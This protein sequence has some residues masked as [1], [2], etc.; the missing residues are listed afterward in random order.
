MTESDLF[1]RLVYTS[2]ATSPVD[3]IALAELSR[4]RNRRTGI[5]GGL[6]VIDAVY[7]QYLEGTE[8]AVEK[9]FVKI[10]EDPRH[11]DVKVLERR[12]TP[13]RMF[14]NWRMALLEWTD[15][16]RDIYVSF[17]PGG[18]LDLYQTDPSTAAPL[19]RAWAATSDWLKGATEKDD[20][21]APCP[22]G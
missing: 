21:A 3:A 4:Q 7:L 20:G 9:L 13:R 12:H 6:A 17:T 8:E 5:T 1:Y 22:E 18:K 10:L 15:R 14:T 19:F 2:R 16:T 11:C